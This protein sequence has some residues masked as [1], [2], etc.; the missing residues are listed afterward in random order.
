MDGEGGIDGWV[1]AKGMGKLGSRVK[2]QGTGAR[3]H[4][5]PWM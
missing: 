4:D 5:G 3:E 1:G 2:S